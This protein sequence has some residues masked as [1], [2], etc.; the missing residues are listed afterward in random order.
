MNKAPVSSHELYERLSHITVGSNICVYSKE[1]CDLLFPMVEKINKLKK[2]KNAIILAHSYVAP[3][4]IYGVADFVGDSY[5]LSKNAV[6]TNAQIIIFSAVKFMA[7]TAKLLNP[8]KQVY[9]PSDFNGCSLADSITLDQLKQLK[10]DYPDYTFVC[11]INTSAEIKSECDVCVTSSNVYDIVQEISNDKIYFLP[12]KLMAKNL[13]NEMESRGVTKDIKYWDGTCYVHEDYD[14]E[15]ID[16]LKVKHRN[17]N[18]VSHPECNENI[19]QKS[20][21]VGSTSQ[22]M[23]HVQNTNED[24]YFILTECGL[25]SRLKQELPN[26]NFVGTCMVCKYMKANQLQNILSTL[27]NPKDSQNIVIEKTVGHDAVNSIQ[28]MFMYVDRIN[29]KKARTTKK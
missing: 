12:D 4:I 8:D 29:Q 28:N 11:Y 22:I 21:Y 1:K 7:E 14:P 24:A 27:E 16:Y 6:Q 23:K 5:E 3:E 10:L 9:I 20:D 26:K 25:I 18:I 2:E 19:I 13:I 15:M 17:L